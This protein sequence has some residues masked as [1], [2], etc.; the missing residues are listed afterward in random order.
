[1]RLDVKLLSHSHTRLSSVLVSSTMLRRAQALVLVIALLA[2]PLALYARSVAGE[3]PSCNGM[4]CLPE[5]HHSQLLAPAE[6]P[7]KAAAIE[8]EPVSEMECHHHAAPAA[9]STATK[10][11][12]SSANASAASSRMPSQCCE[13]HCAMHPRP[14]AM[15]FGLLAP[16]A[17]TKPSDLAAIRIAVAATSGICIPTAVAHSGHEASP[18]QPPRA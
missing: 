7:A 3:M 12:Q 9:K 2:A 18:F 11:R 15:N 10:A 17:P 6:Q 13:F 1:M 8:S 14:H 16:I 5:H 4:C